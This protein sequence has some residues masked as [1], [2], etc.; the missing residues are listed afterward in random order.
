M[1]FRDIT[2]HS[3]SSSKYLRIQSIPP[4]KHSTYLT[5][6]S[7]FTPFEEVILVYAE[8]HAKHINTKC[9]VTDC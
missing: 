4:R 2:H 8:H 1:L 3:R 6:I 7:W 5:K 9:G